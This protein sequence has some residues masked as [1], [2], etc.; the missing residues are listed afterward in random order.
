M[1]VGEQAAR[2]S[3]AIAVVDGDRAVTYRELGLAA[4]RT[5]D[6]PPTGC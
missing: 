3:D 5:A 2:T 6:V 4:N 1:L